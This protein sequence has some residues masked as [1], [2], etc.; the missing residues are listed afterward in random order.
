MSDVK[1]PGVGPVRFSAQIKPG[2]LGA[3]A[4][5][6]VRSVICNRPDGE[7]PDQPAAA[8]IEAA[9]RAA[10][11]DFLHAPIS[12]WPD[13][14]TIE[15]VADRLGPAVPTLMY[16]RSGTRSA[17]VWALAM[18]ASGRGEPDELRAIAAAAGHDLSRL[19][20]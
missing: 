17:M 19:P 14:E 2:D 10:G 6:G 7:D 16:C 9:A 15:A 20:L 1:E 3:L 18:R 5:S 11:L 13:P 8:E 12:G 4:E